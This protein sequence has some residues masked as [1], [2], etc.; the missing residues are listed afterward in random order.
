MQALEKLKQ[1]ARL[2]EARVTPRRSR[3]EWAGQTLRVVRSL[4]WD[5]TPQRNFREEIV[6]Y[7]NAL[8][9]NADYRVIVDAGAATGLFSMAAAISFPDA[10]VFAF[11]PSAR[12]GVLLRRN[13]RLNALDRR[14]TVINMGLWERNDVLA[15]RTHGAISSLQSVS[16][17]PPGYPFLEKIRVIPLDQ[18]AIEAG[19]GPVAL[20]KMDIE[21]A[22]IEALRGA[23]K[24]LRSH[25]PDL[26]VQA[27]HLRDGKRTLETCA[28]FLN[29]C[30]YACQELEGQP[31]MLRATH[32]R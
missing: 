11:E 29:T 28:A 22:E 32:G 8:P 31:G 10:S 30:G 14:I 20:I 27:Y 12:Q 25:H 26:L 6:L 23:E 1:T 2:L 18:W 24:I 13:I 19:V 5:E 17:L 16:Q 9:K 7:L 15:F 3:I 4:W 21:G